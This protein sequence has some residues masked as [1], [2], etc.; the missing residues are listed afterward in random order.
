MY[1]LCKYY[2]TVYKGLK[3]S[4]NFVS[5]I[6]GGFWNQSPEGWLCKQP[7]N[8]I[9]SKKMQA[10]IRFSDYH[11][12]IYIY[13]HIYI[14]IYIYIYIYTHIYIHIYIYI[15]IYTHT[16]IYKDKVRM[17]KRKRMQEFPLHMGWLRTFPER[18]D[19]CN[20]KTV[21]SGAMEPGAGGLE[22]VHRE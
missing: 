8:Q 18:Q 19:L 11:I 21:V 13:T 16:H 22:E 12:Y 10:D 15:Y 5:M 1:I 17:W 20:E 4:Q 7:K 3:C 6:C 9:T 14:H 2:P